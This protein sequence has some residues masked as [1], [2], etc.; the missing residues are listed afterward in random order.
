MRIRRITWKPGADSLPRIT[1][2]NRIAMLGGFVVY[3]R[4]NEW[5]VRW[6]R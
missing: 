4:H 3:L 2:G 6:P 1:A 5:L